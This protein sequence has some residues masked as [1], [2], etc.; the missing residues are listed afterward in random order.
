MSDDEDDLDLIPRSVRDKLDRVGIK[1]H[2]RDWQ[3]LSL[4]ERRDL[5]RQPCD[6]SD[7]VDLYRRSL[8][9]MIRRR[10]G[11]APEYLPRRS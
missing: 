9:D 11:N 8:E 4:A 10:I 1:L 6:S 5:V 3:K 2:L 7:D